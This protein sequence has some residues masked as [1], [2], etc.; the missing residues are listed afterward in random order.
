MRTTNIV[1]PRCQGRGGY[2]VATPADLRK[3]RE[4][5][6]LRLSDVA[7]LT[8]LSVAY[9]SHLERGVRPVTEG[10]TRVYQRLNGKAA[11]PSVVSGNTRQGKRAKR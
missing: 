5:A 2:D 3:A 10:I 4:A 1:C 7:D 11:S 9:L 8:G 6:G